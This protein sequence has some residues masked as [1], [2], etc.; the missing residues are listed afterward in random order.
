MKVSISEKSSSGNINNTLLQVKPGEAAAKF[1]VK[2]GQTLSIS[3]DDQALGQ[4]VTNNQQRFKLIKEAEDLLLVDVESGQSVLVLQDFY[5]EPDVTLAGDQWLYPAESQLQNIGGNLVSGLNPEVVMASVVAAPAATWSGPIIAGWLGA[6]AL[7]ISS[8]SKSTPTDESATLA[9]EKIIM[10]VQDKT[11]TSTS[12]DALTYITAG[13]TGVNSNNLAAINDAL[14]HTT[15]KTTGEIQ[16]LV[17]SYSTI[18]SAADG[19]VGN[20][21]TSPTASDYAA[22]GVSGVTSASQAALLNSVVDGLA[23]TAVD[24]II[25]LQTLADAAGNVLAAAISA[26]GGSVSAADLTALGIS[27]VTIDN[28]AMVQVAIAASATDG[29]EVD[30]QAELQILVSDVLSTPTPTTTIATAAFSAD[31]GTNTTD[32]ITNTAAQT[33]SGT[34]SASVVTGDVVSV[35]LDNGATW[36][37][38]ST[39]VGA[40]TWSLA[41]QTLSASDTLQVKVTDVAGNEGAVYSQAYVLDTS[42]LEIATAAFS[43]DTGT[44]TTDFITNT[45]AQTISGTLSASVVT[46]DVV[47]VSLDNGAT[48]TTA[49]TTVGANTW[50]LAGQ[51][52]SASDTLQVKVTDVAGNEGA[53]YSQAYVL[54]TRADVPLW[55]LNTDSGLYNQDRVTNNGQIDITGLEI[56]AVWQYSLDNGVTWLNG[57]NSN[58]V[59]T[60]TDSFVL[61]AGVY[62]EEQILIRQQDVAGNWGE[63]TNPTGGLQA[64]PLQSGQ[65]AVAGQFVSSTADGGYLLATRSDANDGQNSDV[66]VQHYGADQL[67]AG[68][69]LRLRGMDGNNADL[70]PIVS[71]LSDGGYVVAWNGATTDSQGT[72]IF[73]QR[74]D[75]SDATVGSSIRLA[76][77]TGNYADT[78]PLLQALTNG[79]FVVVWRGATATNGTD[80]FVQAYDADNL[81]VGGLKQ[82]AGAT[83]NFSDASP[84]VTAFADGS[85]AVAWS[86]VTSSAGYQDIYL[87]RYDNTHMAQGSLVQ[88]AGVAGNY[89]DLNPQIATLADGGYIV[90]W[91][92]QTDNNQGTDIFIQRYAA[93]NTSVGM[94]SRLQGMSGTLADSMVKVASLTDG[95]YVLSWVGGTS[96]SQGTDIFVQRYDANGAAVNAVVRLQGMSGDLA[97]SSCVVAAGQNGGYLVAWTGVTSDGQS[98]D[99]FAQ[100]YDAANQTMSASPMRITAVNSATSDVLTPSITAL[101]NGG[102]VVTWQE[103][104]T[105]IALALNPPSQVYTQH[106]SPL[107][108]DLSEPASASLA[109]VLDSGINND[110]IT[111]DATISVANLEHAATWEYQIDTGS[112]IAGSGSSFEMLTD[113][114]SHDYSVRQTDIADTLSSPAALNNVVFDNTGPSIAITTSSVDQFLTWSDAKL[115]SISGTVSDANAMA[116]Q[117]VNVT[118]TDD[119][120]SVITT[121]TTVLDDLTWT[122]LDLDLTS[123]SDGAINVS[124]TVNDAA[125]NTTASAATTTMNLQKTIDILNLP[126]FSDFFEGG[127]FRTLTL[128]D[129]RIVAV[130][131]YTD[132][133]TDSLKATDRRAFSLF[134]G[135]TVDQANGNPQNQIIEGMKLENGNNYD[136]KLLTLLDLNEAATVYYTANGDNYTGFFATSGTYPT[137]QFAEGSAPLQRV[138]FDATTGEFSS[139][140]TVAASETAFYM[141]EIVN[142]PQAVL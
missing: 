120:N 69:P 117:T 118:F 131:Q 80:I 45:A 54:D 108:V 142:Y 86:G 114:L 129:G 24:S 8:A 13:V 20:T 27:G 124:A 55:T 75:S 5:I 68:D 53:V 11:A 34:L 82:L 81:A 52:L 60:S 43:A 35:S 97:D 119:V 122:I 9:I 121:S 51:T 62:N 110:F 56:G 104:D 1:K 92:G 127:L 76:G 73:V 47:S 85:Y 14:N 111:S 15:V 22:I 40:N 125:G 105:D 70:T 135:N 3:V 74:F 140:T 23:D 36:T 87:Q 93:D 77:A 64:I 37:T 67:S 102:Y 115:S 26:D 50:S 16:A 100:A 109:L 123:L 10:A 107:Q 98:I 28:V 134:T 63:V 83:G 116:G 2:A 72:D 130:N 46:G 4:K 32:F 42:P 12:P 126:A 49:S 138:N 44:N 96:D 112:W 141:F 58:P 59:A 84:V 106:I 61:T 128:S 89:R 65:T 137:A 29:S 21:V 139:V 113:G 101:S 18:L 88:L 71:T 136:L 57:N 17:Q 6:G 41:G 19:V 7:S 133:E 132:V 94:P 48:W 38:A 25:E 31:T 103:K 39:T 33:I 99:L 78:I 91:D 90:S 66:Y 79:S 30:T 95:G